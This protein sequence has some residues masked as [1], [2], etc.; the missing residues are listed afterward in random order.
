MHLP[1]PSEVRLDQDRE[2]WSSPVVLR[3]EGSQGDQPLGLR[4]NAAAAYLFGC[5]V[6]SL[7]ER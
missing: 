6:G 7:D 2:W 1:D 5:W 4:R 3:F